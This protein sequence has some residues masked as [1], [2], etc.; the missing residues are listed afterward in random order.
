MLEVYNKWIIFWLGG[1][2]AGMIGIYAGYTQ[3]GTDVM[4]AAVLCMIGGVGMRELHID[5]GSLDT[6]SDQSVAWLNLLGAIWVAWWTF[7]IGAFMFHFQIMERLVNW[8]IA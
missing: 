7:I 4:Q 8:V 3:T 5:R 6:L 1:L 2:I